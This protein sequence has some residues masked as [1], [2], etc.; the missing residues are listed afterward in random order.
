[1]IDARSFL[2]WACFVAGISKK[3]EE[4]SRPA[5]ATVLFLAE[6]YTTGAIAR[7]MQIT[8]H[9]AARYVRESLATLAAQEWDDVEIQTFELMAEQVSAEESPRQHFAALLDALR[10]SQDPTPRTV[11]Y[12][13]LGR[14]VGGRS[15][16]VD[17]DRAMSAC[18]GIMTFPAKMQNHL[19]RAGVCP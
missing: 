2:V 15:P 17:V 18:A 6:G 12:D 19:T 7:E 4:P 14:P 3:R 5:Q 10:N 11:E 8:A 9:Q 1:M 16:L 13:A